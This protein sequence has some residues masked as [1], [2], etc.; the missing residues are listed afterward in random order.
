MDGLLYACVSKNL[1]QGIGSFWFPHFS[2][3]LYSFFDQQPP[4][5]FWM[6]SI[7]F[8]LLGNSMYVERL[9][10]FLTA[11]ITAV[12]IILLWRIILKNENEFKKL[13]WLPV[14]FWITI[15]VCFWAYSNNLLENT[16]GIFDLLAITSIVLFFH[17]QSFLLIILSG[18]FIFLATLTKGFQGMFP[19][20]AIFFGWLV[21]RNISFSKMLIATLLL[22]FTPVVIYCIVLQNTDAYQSLTT[23]LN[24]RVITSIKQV[25]NVDNRF[26]ILLRLFSELT[27]LILF[28]GFI[29][30]ISKFKNTKQNIITPFF[31]NHILFF[32]LIG[33]SASLPLMI[34]L[35]QSSFY[36]VTS[37][38]YYAVAFAIAIAPYLSTWIEKL[39][40]K[41]LSFK[42]FQ[43]ASAILLAAVLTLS[44]L[45]IGGIERDEDIIHDIRLIGKIVPTGTTM[46]STQEL[47]KE[48]SIQEYLIRHYYICQSDKITPE[49]D[50]LLLESESQIPAGI[51]TQKVNI[52]TIKYNLYK[53]IK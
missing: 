46:G 33:V 42:L 26:F 9:Y 19:L 50:F 35:E 6:Q 18:V 37:L 34:T 48:W 32:L 47:W 28:S 24:N 4:L 43:I 8:K 14:L 27:P 36:L 15:P 41:H 44:F 38:P 51:K 25:V 39:N 11:I 23:Y 49:N 5:G 40:I 31:K 2:K 45:Q 10:S 52:P 29:I 13:S 30:I 16:M 20:A 17:K 21:Y 3:T 7:F 22:T 12:L 53:I 1:S